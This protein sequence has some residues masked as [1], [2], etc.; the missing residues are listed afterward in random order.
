MTTTLLTNVRLF[1]GGADLTAASNK[2]ELGAEREEKD[3]TTFLPEGDA[4]SGFKKVTGGLAQAACAATGFW[5]AGDNGKVDDRSW[6]D[7]GG[8]TGWTIAPS[9]SA[10]GSLAYLMKAMRGKYIQGGQVG[11]INPYSADCKS[12]WPLVRGLMLHPSGTARSSTGNGTAVQVSAVS[13]TQYLYS[14]LHVLSVSG[15]ATL[16]AT[17][18]SDVDNTFASPA[19][20][21]TFTLASAIS[22]EILRTAGAITDTWYR[23]KY[24][25]GG[26][27]SVL[28][29]CSVGV[30]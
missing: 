12:D 28:F 19:T 9:S 4:D 5:E 10:A 7:L 29:A 24:T 17:I 30:F 20:Q 6:A 16:T 23:V 26:T 1:T 25:I 13:A 27:G 3:V 11:D 21:I 8:L 18:E 15:T 2:V 14:S 22:G